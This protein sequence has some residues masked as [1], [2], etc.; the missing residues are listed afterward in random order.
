MAWQSWTARQWPAARRG[1]AGD[2]RTVTFSVPRWW[3][4]RSLRARVTMTTTLGLA[5]ALAAAA[6][7]LRGAVQG[8]LTREVD[9]SARQGA[10]EVAALAD[11]NQLPRTVLAGTLT[12]QVLRPD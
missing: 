12:V 9:G 6:L 2:D 4:R 7:L 5:V 3:R 11:T 10:R 8:S 1:R